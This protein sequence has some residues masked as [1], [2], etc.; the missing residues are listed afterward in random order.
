VR[1][2]SKTLMATP[3][4]IIQEWAN[5]PRFIPIGSDLLYVGNTS[6]RCACGT[7]GHGQAGRCLRHA[8]MLAEST[9]PK[10]HVTR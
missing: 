7:I 5:D 6:G 10:G 3:V 4:S 9:A 1:S 8:S 2:R